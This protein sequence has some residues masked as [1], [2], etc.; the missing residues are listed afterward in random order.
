MI[1]LVQGFDIISPLPIDGRILL[2]SNEMKE[3]ADYL[4]PDKY[5]AICRDD[6]KLYLYDK[7]NVITE[8]SSI[9]YGKF[10]KANNDPNSYTDKEITVIDTKLDNSIETVNNTVLGENRDQSIPDPD[11]EQGVY[12]TL[13]NKVT[14]EAV[15]WSTNLNTETSARLQ[16]DDELNLKIDNYKTNQNLVNTTELSSTLSNYPTLDNAA[17]YIKAYVDKDYKL[18]IQLEDNNH[19]IISTDNSV[20]LP[21]EHLIMDVDYVDDSQGKALVIT[22]QGEDSEGE[23]KTLR[24]P[25]DAMIAGLVSEP[26][27]NA[28]VDDRNVHIQDGE[29]AKWNNA[30]E[31]AITPDSISEYFVSGVNT[32]INKDPGTNKVRIDAVDTTYIAGEG[33]GIYP[34]EGS[35]YIYRVT[36]DA[37]AP[38]WDTIEGVNPRSNSALNSSFESVESLINTK[39][40]TITSEKL[41]EPLFIDSEGKIGI[42]WASVNKAGKVSLTN[43]VNSESASV[44][45]SALA[46]KTAYDLAYQANSEARGASIAAGAAQTRADDAYGLASEAKQQAVS[47]TNAANSKM[48]TFT[49]ATATNSGLTVTNGSEVQSGDQITIGH[50]NKLQSAQTTQAVYPI[51][52]D[53]NGHIS[54]FGNAVTI[55]TVTDTYSPTSSNAMSG[56]AV[57]SALN[58]L[59]DPMIFK[60]S[61]GSGGTVATLPTTNVKVGDT[62][63]VITSNINIPAASSSTGSAVT[64]KIGDTVIST[65]PAPKWT[66]IPSGDEPSGTVTSVGV[67]PGLVSSTAGAITSSGTLSVNLLNTTKLTGDTVSRT[68][69]ANRTYS[70]AIDKNDHL[71]VNVPWE[72]TQSNYGNVTTDGKITS[73]TQIATGDKIVIVDSS[74]SSKLTSTTISF[75]TSK[76]NLA[77][78]QAGT[79]ASFTNNTG[80]VT[81]VKVSSDNIVQGSVTGGSS[82]SEIKTSGTISLSH[83]ESGVTSGSYGPTQAT[84]TNIAP[85]GSIT[86]PYITVNAT[87]HITAASS[88][89]LNIPGIDTGR[90]LVLNNN[91]IGIRSISA[92]IP[93]AGWSA[94][95]TA[96]AGKFGF[97]NT[98]TVEGITANSSP[99]IDLNMSNIT[100]N[101]LDSWNEAWSKIYR[102]ET[103]ANTITFYSTEQLSIDLSV[104]IKG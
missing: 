67:G 76:S 97:K 82:S 24:V 53:I 10:R 18:I 27:F 28:H 43:A 49:L 6:G 8:D 23:H 21:I 60:G 51:K 77:L 34:V 22:L 73:A 72:N 69:V 59:P 104:N 47:A 36:T 99:V 66:V 85:G 42:E 54:S 56:K 65:D 52:I 88:K 63:K 58:A 45:A 70:V 17:R 95:S 78:T 96:A 86:V 91:L 98:V 14:D 75:D 35:P 9:G 15:T 61:V 33:I 11:P 5:F 103:G 50:N 102:A 101:W 12:G 100:S 48:S 37:S 74:D 79:W 93:S 44:A 1:K 25:L 16:K 31:N 92:T 40:D 7:S 64:A 71:A 94:I 32:T 4:L 57:A 80:T 55:P 3:I 38:T 29:R 2:S 90:G 20:D 81:S 83:A 68:D 62:Y 30:A 41:E 39:Q 87:G 26:I 89:A 19:T 84:N 13:W 46:V